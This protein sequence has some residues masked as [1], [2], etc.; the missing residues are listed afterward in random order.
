[1][2]LS[3]VG[4]TL[5]TNL[6]LTHARILWNHL[7]G[8]V[9]ADGT[10]GDLAANDFTAQRWNAPAGVASW[11]LAAN[12]DAGVDTVFIAAHNL[13]GGTVRVFTP[14]TAFDAWVERVSVAPADNSTIAI[15]FNRASGPRPIVLVGDTILLEDGDTLLLEDDDT[16]VMEGG[17]TT[18]SGLRI[19][20]ETATG[21]QIGIIRAG[22][23]LQMERPFYGGHGPLNWNRATEGEPQ[24]TEGGQ[25][26]GQIVRRISQRATYE[27]A[28]LT[29]AWYDANFE[30]F[31]RTLPSRP[32]GIVGN[33]D[34]LAAADV[35]W[36]WTG[37]DVS[38]QLMGIRDLV[39]V[40][41]PVTG[42]AG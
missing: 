24:M 28:H 37:Q 17:W 40:S 6:P 32:F 7:T 1:M 3:T 25:W 5:G 22:V 31:A 10:N 26:V 12:D 15:L 4:Y 30:P 8:P 23:A 13:A 20:V 19:E 34:R 27:W 14:N 9:T 36:C 16:A 38:P 29:Q 39:S 11:T 2:T 18:V 21:A 33:P 41:L 35:G 42:Y